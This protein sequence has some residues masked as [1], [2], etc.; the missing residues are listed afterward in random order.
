[1]VRVNRESGGIWEFTRDLWLQSYKKCG[2]EQYAAIKI[3]AFVN[4][5]FRRREQSGKSWR[6][7]PSPENWI[8]SSSSMINF[9]SSAI[10]TYLWQTLS[11]YL[12]DSLSHA[13]WSLADASPKRNR[14][15]S[16]CSCAMFIYKWPLRSII[17]IRLLTSRRERIS[18][19]F[20]SGI[21]AWVKLTVLVRLCLKNSDLQVIKSRDLSSKSKFETRRRRRR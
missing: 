1:M 10:T 7:E 13:E 4:R 16:Q 5:L 14:I 20:N 3:F 2:P 15:S 8:A 18:E 19:C 17:N 21:I 12:C 9:H 11:F 6:E